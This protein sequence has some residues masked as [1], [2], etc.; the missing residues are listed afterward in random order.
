LVHAGVWRNY[1]SE[2]Y[3][4]QTTEQGDRPL[5]QIEIRLPADPE[6]LCVVRGA[7]EKVTEVSGLSSPESESVVLAVCEALSN[8]IDHSYGGRCSEPIIV[9]LGRR[10]AGPKQAAALAIVVR[11]FGKQVDPK[12]IKSRNLS[13]V[14]PG[15]LGV[16]II[17]SV[18]DEV[19]Y[20]HARGGGMQLRM[21][22]HIGSRASGRG[23]ANSNKVS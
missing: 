19:E 10:V 20:S 4:A 6:Y 21:A 22:K 12:R 16:H 7:V 15:G 9:T 3:M 2:T 14:K 18:M 8:V 13:D 23:V 17:R 5:G 11:D 1:T